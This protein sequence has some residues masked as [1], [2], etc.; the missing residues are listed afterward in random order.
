MRST[1]L[2]GDRIIVNNISM[3]RVPKSRASLLLAAQSHGAADI[4]DLAGW[5]ALPLLSPAVSL[6]DPLPTLP[7]S[8]DLLRMLISRSLRGYYEGVSVWSAEVSGRSG[9]ITVISRLG[10]DVDD[11]RSFVEMLIGR[12]VIRLSEMKGGP[13]SEGPAEP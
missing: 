5:P 6:V 9:E 4:L 13:E 11:V 8:G 2:T 1:K 7:K 12:E 3:I 10:A